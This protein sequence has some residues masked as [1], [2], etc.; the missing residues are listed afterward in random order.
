M[1]CASPHP[2]TI[3]FFCLD[4]GP[5]S[6][7][8]NRNP[9]FVQPSSSFPSWAGVLLTDVG[10]LFA[11]IRDGSDGRSLTRRYFD[12][13]RTL[14]IAPSWVIAQRRPH[15]LIRKER[16]TLMIPCWTA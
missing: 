10:R 3:A 16:A 13:Q 1:S 9:R 12:D 5:G 6:R 4:F 14:R 11:P 8:F 15:H 2:A 7:E